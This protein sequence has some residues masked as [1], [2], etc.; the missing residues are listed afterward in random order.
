MYL[1]TWLL[2]ISIFVLL[3]G[4]AAKNSETITLNYYFDKS[5]DLPLSVVLLLFFALGIGLTYLSI[6]RSK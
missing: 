2:R 5:H 1:I 6:S 4:F 3:V